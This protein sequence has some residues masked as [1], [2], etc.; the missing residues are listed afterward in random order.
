[1]STLFTF[2]EHYDPNQE[3][4]IIGK[5]GN[6]IYRGKAG[7]V[8]QRVSNKTTVVKETVMWT[9]DAIRIIVNN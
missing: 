3:I 4:L 8:P 9:G 6:Q 1:M 5:D 7:D 2:L